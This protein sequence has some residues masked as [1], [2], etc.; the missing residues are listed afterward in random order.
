LIRRA[1]SIGED[2]PP[3]VLPG[4]SSV[5]EVTAAASEAEVATIEGSGGS[6]EYDSGSRN[7]RGLTLGELQVHC[8]R[9]R[10]IFAGSY[11]EGIVPFNIIYC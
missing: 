3:L 10:S 5:D 4:V 8:V 11:E 2:A 6:E 7:D 1:S 9:M